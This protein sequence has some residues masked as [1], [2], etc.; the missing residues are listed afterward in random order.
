M[1]NVLFLLDTTE[2]IAWYASAYF[3]L[4]DLKREIETYFSAYYMIST[5][6]EKLASADFVILPEIIRPFVKI[7]DEKTV[8]TISANLF[9]SENFEQIKEIIDEH[10][11]ND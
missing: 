8:I 3:E 7:P 11:L 1:P 6:P 10:R 5:K 4:S 9:L 2:E